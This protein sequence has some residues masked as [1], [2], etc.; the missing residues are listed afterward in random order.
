[1]KI[2]KKILLITIFTGI[3]S[4]ILFFYFGIKDTT[5]GGWAPPDTSLKLNNHENNWVVTIEKKYQGTFDYIGLDNQFTE[6]SIIYIILNCHNKDIFEKN[7]I[8]DKEK[9]TKELC[10]NFFS[11][12]DFRRPQDYI[13]FSYTYIKEKNEKQTISLEFLYYKNLDSIVKK[14]EF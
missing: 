9:F 10:E 4:F 1:M 11:N 13:Y 3:V 5:M 2:L 14:D 6:D 7:H 8:V 12:S